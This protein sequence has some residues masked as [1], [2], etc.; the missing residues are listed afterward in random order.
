MSLGSFPKGGENLPNSFRV[1]AVREFGTESVGFVHPLSGCLVGLKVW[2]R[3]D[4]FVSVRVGNQGFCHRM[5][6]SSVLKDGEN[7]P[8]AFRVCAEGELGTESVGFVTG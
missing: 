6:L 1:C 2:S 5:T 8:K 3:C 7:L 4:G